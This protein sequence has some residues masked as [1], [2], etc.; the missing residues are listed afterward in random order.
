MKIFVCYPSS[1]CWSEAWKVS[2]QHP[3]SQTSDVQHHQSGAW[4]IRIVEGPS[5]VLTRSLVECIS[6]YFRYIQLHQVVVVVVVVVVGVV[7]VVVVVVVAVVVVA[8]VVVAVVV[9]AVVV[10]V[11]AVVVVVEA[12]AVPRL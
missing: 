11:V 9:V 4:G 7:V 10:V 6:G 1:R 12:E 3:I 2:V 8:V 5:C